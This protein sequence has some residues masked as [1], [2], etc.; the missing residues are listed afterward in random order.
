DWRTE[1]LMLITNP[2]V[3]F[4]LMLLGVYG[5]I[6][7]FLSPG[8]VAPGLIGAISLLVALYALAFMPIN[9]VGAAL[10]LLG[11]ALMIP[12]VDIGAFGA[13]GRRYRCVCHRRI[14]DVS[15]RDAGLCAVGQRHHRR[16]ARQRRAVAARACRGLAASAAGSHRTRSLDRRRR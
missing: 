13:L 1:L 3:A 9:Y 12:E 7:E 11:V 15:K 14:D 16:G 6:F 2:N 4:I 10:V 5:L 8:A